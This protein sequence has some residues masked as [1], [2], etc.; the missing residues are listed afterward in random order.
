MTPTTGS[1][2]HW[3]TK[4]LAILG[5][6]ATAVPAIVD[7]SKQVSRDNAGMCVQK[8][9]PLVAIKRRRTAD[10]SPL[11][12][13]AKR[14]RKRQDTRA[15]IKAKEIKHTWKA[16]SQQISSKSTG[17]TTKHLRP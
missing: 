3:N 8:K 17:K 2:P 12:P 16:A 7:G 5:W 10:T 1:G 6:D 13:N 9:R 4:S 15:A 11:N 14:V